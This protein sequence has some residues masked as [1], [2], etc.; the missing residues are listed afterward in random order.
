[1]PG[2][3]T[4]V[5]ILQQTPLIWRHTDID[6]ELGN[7]FPYAMDDGTGSVADFEVR[8]KVVKSFLGSAP[9]YNQNLNVKATEEDVS[10]I[11]AIVR[12]APKSDASKPSFEWPFEVNK[13]GV[14]S[15]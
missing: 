10:R 14:F 15:L 4:S 7:R 13:D 12:A 6:I 11:K 1:M 8:G 2:A 9:M 3:P 5:A